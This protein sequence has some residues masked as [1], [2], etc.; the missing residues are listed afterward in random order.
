MGQQQAL[1]AAATPTMASLGSPSNF[2]NSACRPQVQKFTG[3]M[4]LVDGSQETC[5]ITALTPGLADLT[6]YAAEDLKGAS[7]AAIAGAAWRVLAAPRAPLECWL[8]LQGCTQKTQCSS[9]TPICQ[10][11]IG[12]GVAPLINLCGARHNAATCSAFLLFYRPRLTRAATRLA[13][14]RP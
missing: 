11:D 2:C 1:N 14:C 8:R 3:A 10:T 6:G 4:M 12:A 13:R 7:F 9:A 5:P